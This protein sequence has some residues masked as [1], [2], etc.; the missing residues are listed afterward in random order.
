VAL[1][2][3]ELNLFLRGLLEWYF[4][5]KW[6]ATFTDKFYGLKRV[7]KI[8]VEVHNQDQIFNMIEGQRRLNRVQIMGSLL[9]LVGVDYIREKLD[10]TFDQLK[11]KVALRQLK[12]S[13]WKSWMKV[14]F[15]KVYPGAKRALRILNLLCQIMYLSGRSK[16]PSLIDWLLKIEYSRITQFDHE[17]NEK[18][19][20]EV[21]LTKERT[22]P[23]SFGQ[24][25]MMISTKYYEPLQNMVS[26]LST[27][28][29]PLAIFLLKF[30]E[31]WN[32]SEFA[33]KLS[34]QRFEKD[35][36]PPS[37]ADRPLQNSEKCP[38]CQN[39]ITNHAIIETGY[40]F[41][42]PCITRHLA[43]G[44]AK[45]GGRCPVTGQRLLGCRY[46]Y[47]SKEWKVDG[48]RRLII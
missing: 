20:G 47:A 24:Q 4:V 31:W 13:D 14:Y 34:S 48:I 23:P 3:D 1:R 15:V 19:K 32:S 27:T 35:I 17:L 2:F 30:L 22:R 36:P 46:D 10:V 7:S 25:F 38:L 44:D 5:R 42:Y 11:A 43:E 6:N 41:C 40:V 45:H 16:S 29:F 8:N 18:P 21:K 28:I 33:S 39:G 37:Q 9:N 12:I 26:Q